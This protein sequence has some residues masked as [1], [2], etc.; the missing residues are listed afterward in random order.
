MPSKKVLRVCNC[1]GFSFRHVRWSKTT[2][3]L[4]MD[5]LNIYKSTFCI[6]MF[7]LFDPLSPLMFCQMNILSPYVLSLCTF[8]PSIRFVH[9]DILSLKFCLSNFLSIRMFCP[10]TLSPNICLWRFWLRTSVTD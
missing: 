10:W 1:C 9:L 8:C 4:R 2:G 6:W 5:I 3:I 7:C